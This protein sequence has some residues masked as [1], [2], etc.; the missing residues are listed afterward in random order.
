[1]CVFVPN[2]KF[3]QCLIVILLIQFSCSI[4]I[5]AQPYGGT[6]FIDPDIITSEDPSIFKNATYLGTG[7]RVVYDRRAQNWITINAFLFEVEF[8]DG[9][10]CEAIV[11]PEF[12]DETLS[13]I[14]VEKY[15]FYIGQLPKALRV[16]IKELWIHKGV[17]PFGGGNHSIL[18]HTGQA[19]NYI[20]D[21]IIEETLIHEASH[22]SLDAFH[23][24]AQGWIAAQMA[25]AQFIS[26][27]ARD[28]PT[29]EDIAE[30]FLTWI[31]VRFK[32][33]KIS[34]TD[35][36]NIV[37]TIPNRL[38]YFDQ[39][40]F[41]L[42]PLESVSDVKILQQNRIEHD[43]KIFPNPISNYLQIF[44]KEDSN[45]QFQLLDLNGFILLKD[46]KEKTNLESYPNGVYF[47]QIID[48]KTNLN[49]SKKIVLENK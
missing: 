24:E 5:L 25:D 44:K 14:E 7:S 23:A 21:G 28:N 34:I 31:A 32:E 29:R 9:S 20:S 17:N 46:L 42:A 3:V 39:Q 13:A 30:S 15:G 48:N 16:D 6:L 4:K 38:S 27:Y 43:I 8:E 33:D 1:M 19:D 47:L 36:G 35:F 2:A 22:T 41:D 11:N 45:Y 10:S 49:Y 26:T 12:T 40:N 18:I 37:E